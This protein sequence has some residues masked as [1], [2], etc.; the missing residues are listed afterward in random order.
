[1]ASLHTFSIEEDSVNVNSIFNRKEDTERHTI[2]E[3]GSTRTQL[4]SNVEDI[5]GCETYIDP[6]ELLDK[7]E[8]LDISMADFSSVP[9][10][11][12]DK[13]MNI[14]GNELKDVWSKHKWDIGRTERVKHEIKTE[15][16][17][18]VKDKKVV[19][20]IPSSRNTSSTSATAD[21]SVSSSSTSQSVSTVTATTSG[22]S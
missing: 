10:E 5:L 19:A 16:G 2:M 11:L 12:K 18:T 17:V 15:P 7:E 20:L 1:M 3:D 22:S 6:N 13:L 8:Q 21:Q 4:T 9:E 14:V